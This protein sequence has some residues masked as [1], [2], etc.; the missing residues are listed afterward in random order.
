[1]LSKSRSKRDLQDRV[2]SKIAEKLHTSK[3]VAIS[4]F[5]YFEV[6]FQDDEVAYNM[7]T[8]FGLENDEVKLFR[9]RKIK[10]P[11]KPKAKQVKTDSKPSK[12][13]KKVK[14]SSADKTLTKK[15]KSKDKNSE[16]DISKLDSAKKEDNSEN[17]EKQVSLFS[18]K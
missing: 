17:N 3:K 6:M 2:A 7:M 14:K 18:F 10:I 4:Q 12:N 5:P 9:S 15:K 11:K 8:Y 16:K 1:M 13:V